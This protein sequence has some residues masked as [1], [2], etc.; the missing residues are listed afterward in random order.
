MEES[1]NELRF[2]GSFRIGRTTGNT[3]ETYIG[4]AASYS[5]PNPIDIVLRATLGLLELDLLLDFPAGWTPETIGSLAAK[6]DGVGTTIEL[7]AGQMAELIGLARYV[8]PICER[9]SLFEVPDH[10]DHIRWM[11]GIV[12][13]GDRGHN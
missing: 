12:E 1:G 10:A 11:I 4:H 8:L 5:V 6:T 7:D 2:G 13:G 3:V 9:N